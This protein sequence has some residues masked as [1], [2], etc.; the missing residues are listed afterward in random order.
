[1]ANTG[2][3]WKTALTDTTTGETTSREST[4][5]TNLNSIISFNGSEGSNSLYL[6][7]HRLNGRNY[8]EWAQSVRLVMD[9]KWRL[10]YLTGEVKQPVVGDPTGK[11]WKSENSLIAWLINSM[12]PGIGKPFMFLPTAKEV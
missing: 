4:V 6:T 2:L 11:N 8:M 9:G 5:S 3:T 12:E 1:M 10:G 7:I